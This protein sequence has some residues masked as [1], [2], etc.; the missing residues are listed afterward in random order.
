LLVQLRLKYQ[1]HNHSFAQ[2]HALNIIL[3]HKSCI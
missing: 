1:I 3:T 2:N